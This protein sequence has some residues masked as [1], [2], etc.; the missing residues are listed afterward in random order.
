M[1]PKK[2]EEEKTTDQF[3]K[4]SGGTIIKP[5][6]NFSAITNL[7]KKQFKELWCDVVAIIKLILGYQSES[8]E[9][10]VESKYLQHNITKLIKCSKTDENVVLY[11]VHYVY[12]APS[13]LQDDADAL[14]EE[15]MVGIT[16][17]GLILIV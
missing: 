13:Y 7:L 6:M 16:L 4:T 14:F 11:L 10:R 5:L 8:N 3:P 17:I 9:I 1:G 2:N 15:L 12:G